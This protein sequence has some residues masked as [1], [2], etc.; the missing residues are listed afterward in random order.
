MLTELLT[1][2]LAVLTALVW[3]GACLL[4]LL[5]LWGLRVW[6]KARSVQPIETK[7][8]ALDA[9]LAESDDFIAKFKAEQAA[10]ERRLR[11]S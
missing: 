10:R 3:V 6:F 4:P 9:F 11:H 5:I 8:D 1:S 2:A 7:P